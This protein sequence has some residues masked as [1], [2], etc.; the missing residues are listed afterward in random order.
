MVPRRTLRSYDE[1][2]QH[3]QAFGVY[4]VLRSRSLLS[5]STSLGA[6]HTYLLRVTEESGAMGTNIRPCL[7]EKGFPA[8]R[9]VRGSIDV[10]PKGTTKISIARQPLCSDC[11]ILTGREL[12]YASTLH[13]HSLYNWFSKDTFPR[14]FL[15]GLSQG[16]YWCT[17]F[18]DIQ[19]MDTQSFPRLI[20][21]PLSLNLVM[22]WYLWVPC[23]K[24]AAVPGKHLKLSISKPSSL[25]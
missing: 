15:S 9:E 24:F 22:F 23:V 3:V 25:I 2:T 16:S 4:Q 1:V 20:L 10:T 12:R 5:S 21:I 8:L 18:P 13:D 6:N 17:L 14:Y 7:S 19:V 11:G